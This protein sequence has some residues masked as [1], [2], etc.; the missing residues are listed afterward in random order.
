LDKEQGRLDNERERIES[1]L[2]RLN[3]G[4]DSMTIKIQILEISDEDANALN[5]SGSRFETT[6]TLTPD[7]ISFFP[8]PGDG[9]LNLTF[10]LSTKAPVRV[11]LNNASGEMV[12]LEERAMFDGQYRKTIDISDEPNGTY[13]L[14]IIQDGKYYSK[15]IIKGF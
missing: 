10:S 3:R 13:F 11:T 8:N 2:D 4:D 12:Y 9:V 6:N 14:Q 5:G 7:Q 1:E 15:K